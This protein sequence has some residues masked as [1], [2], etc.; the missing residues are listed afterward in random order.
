MKIGD[1]VEVIKNIMH[2]DCYLKTRVGIHEGSTGKVID[3]HSVDNTLHAAVEFDFNI[4]PSG[5]PIFIARFD[6]S[7]SP[8][9][10]SISEHLR[11]I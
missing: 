9:S 11:V 5:D 1:H 3:V 10:T 4:N 7:A 2:T 6:N 8:I